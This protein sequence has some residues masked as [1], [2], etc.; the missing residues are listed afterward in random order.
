MIESA[1]RGALDT[2][3]YANEEVQFVDKQFEYKQEKNDEK[4]VYDL[5][6]E[7]LKQVLEM[8]MMDI[9]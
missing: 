3:P 2:F 9:L 1:I 6:D 4:S 8:S 7:I 5:E